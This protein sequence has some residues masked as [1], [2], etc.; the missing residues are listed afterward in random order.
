MCGFLHT[1]EPERCG[2]CGKWWGRPASP[3]GALELRVLQ[4]WRHTLASLQNRMPDDV[5]LSRARLCFSSEL[6]GNSLQDLMTAAAQMAAR[7]FLPSERG[8][9]TLLAFRV[10]DCTVGVLTDFPWRSRPVA[11]DG[12]GFG[13]ASSDCLLFKLAG[14]SSSVFRPRRGA[15]SVLRYTGDGLEVGPQAAAGYG[16][17]PALCVDSTLSRLR[18]APSQVFGSPDMLGCREAS[19]VAVHCLSWAYLEGEALEEQVPLAL[20]Q[21]QDTFMLNFIGSAVRNQIAA[22]AG[23]SWS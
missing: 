18:S 6:H 15:G 8:C 5:F 4:T 11:P 3:E 23:S 1:E 2:R 12:R 21:N 16:M 13:Y 22:K 9:Y 19:V 7:F 10:A 17:E 14:R 20:Q